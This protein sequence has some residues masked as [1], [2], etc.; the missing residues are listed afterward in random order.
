MLWTWR[1]ARICLN[2]GLQ[3]RVTTTCSEWA[4]VR[5][6]EDQD[7]SAHTRLHSATSWALRAW[8]SLFW[9][10]FDT[11][12]LLQT[13]TEQ[14]EDILLQLRQLSMRKHSGPVESCVSVGSPN[15]KGQRIA[16]CSQYGN[17]NAFSLYQ[18]CQDWSRYYVLCHCQVLGIKVEGRT[19]E[20]KNPKC[21]IANLTMYLIH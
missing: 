11:E 15:L 5:R 20:R 4:P 19:S 1:G 17:K 2:G 18:L 14:S 7:V 9:A 12:I 3:R 13:E 8:A 16:G 10:S 21:V 6:A